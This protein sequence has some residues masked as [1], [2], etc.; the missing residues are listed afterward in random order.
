LTFQ[1]ETNLALDPF[2]VKHKIA[3][4]IK[5]HQKQ[6][7]DW[8]RAQADRTPLPFYS[9]VDLRD[10]G[11]KIVPVDSN[12]YPAGFNNICP[13]DLRSAPQV[14]KANLS[15]LLGGTLD[16]LP[17]SQDRP[18]RV[19]VLPESHTS[20]S[21]YIEN[22]YYLI[23]ILRESGL[24][25]EL[26][27]WGD[28]NPENSAL[29]SANTP[30]VIRLE[31]QTQ[32]QLSAWPISIKNQRITLSTHAEWEPDF[33]VLNN[34]FS[35]GYPK[36]LDGV[37]QPI[38]P[39]HTLG[40]HSRKKSTHFKHYNRL[41]TEFA[42]LIGIDPWTITIDTREVTPVDFSEGVGIDQVADQVRQVLDSTRA[43]YK[44]HGITRE[45]FAFVKNNSGT[46]GMGIMV[47]HSADEVLTLNRREKN[48]MSVGKNKMIIESVA[49]QEGVPTATLVDRL[50]SEPVIYLMGCELIGGFLRTNTQRGEEDNLNSQGMV[51]RKLCV[52]DLK[53]PFFDQ[54]DSDPEDA[55]DDSSGEEPLMELVY[56]T[57]A[58]ISAMAAGIE[59]QENA[60]RS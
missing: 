6:V 34:D 57:V 51:F 18:K 24:E 37:K 11:H 50:A 8:Q 22:L 49:I 15:R 25:V 3:A 45:P 1:D 32:K 19:L 12:L 29:P 47:V 36:A 30:E 23:G 35:S 7:I 59:I 2:G 38:F 33:V 14:L 39:T 13:D 53:R 48:K 44:T 58:R 41:A 26:G 40:W 9:S 10:S 16:S 56:G 4:Q 17:G 46:Y 21:Y 54:D 27:W 52:S 60:N 5:A 43:A 55:A 28:R 20:N 31:S 42:Q